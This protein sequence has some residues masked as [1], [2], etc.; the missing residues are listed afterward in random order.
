MEDLP[1]SLLTQ[2]EHVKPRT[3]EELETFGKYAASLYLQGRCGTLSDAVVETVKT[4]G[5][6]PEQ[7]RR[8]VEFANTSAYLTKFAEV[9][10]GHKV[11]T[12]AGGPAAFP[13]VIRDLNDGSGG[14]TYDP[15]PADYSLPPPDVEKM[16]SRNA[17]R[18]GLEDAKLASA[19]QAEPADIPY[20]EP[21]RE[22]LD[23]RDK[24][25]SLYDE[26]TFEISGLETRLM[27]VSN[28]LFQQVKQASLEGVPLGHLVSV[29]G[30]V[31][32]EP[33]FMKVAFE[34]LT[35]RL[36]ANEVF[37]SHS[38]VAT[39]LEKYA[40]AGVVNPAHPLVGIYE[41]YCD[42]LQKLA[43]TRHVRDEVAESLDILSTFIQKS[44]G[45]ASGIREVASKLPKA[46]EAA[47]QGAAKAS[48]PVS[49]FVSELGLPNAAPY[50]GAAVKYS[51]HIAAGLAGED[52]YQRAKAN[53]AVHGASNFVLSR[54]PYTRQNMIRQL[55]LQQGFSY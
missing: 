39:S 26:A 44:A 6:A 17:E 41:D 43:A 30:S 2:Q 18:L 55:E 48:K 3:G 33:I 7:V 51:P 19:F 20:E 36:V 8:V 9:G 10:P 23:T 28:L 31:S 42:T 22:A 29:M 14:S 15:V 12:F 13:D 45:V 27:D 52:L 38:A 25:A 47:T 5:L 37:S 53:P 32:D 40:G 11:V 1:T 46:W 24:L 50:V 16:A 35:P 34:M 21:L 54:V 4:A 49:D